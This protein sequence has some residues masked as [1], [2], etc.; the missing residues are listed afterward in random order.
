MNN[1]E[2]IDKI[3]IKAIAEIKEKVKKNPK[4]LSPV[5]KERLE[6]M[7]RLQFVSGNEFTFWMQQNGI[8]KNLTKA[9]LENRGCK[10]WPEYLDK[11]AQRAGFKNN[12]EKVREWRNE[13]GRCVPIDD[14]DCPLWFGEFTENLMI[15]RYPGAKRMPYNNKGFD[16]LWNG[17]KI[18]HKGRC[19]R[20]TPGRSPAWNF[21]ILFNNSARKFILTGWDNRESLN[22]MYAWEFDRDDIVRG[23]HFWQRN[24]FYITYTAYWLEQ[25]E[26]YQIDIDWLK[27]LL[28]SN[29]ETNR[30]IG[31]K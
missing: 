23:R 17:I 1:I 9:L 11:C 19:L 29:D 25:F 31:E 24:G 16:Y 2:S 15:H 8:M 27:E 3:R 28:R 26:D 14:K 22:P 10:T 12:A 18:D 20:Y 5:N 13:T 30:K 21:G 4:Y 6:D 7:K